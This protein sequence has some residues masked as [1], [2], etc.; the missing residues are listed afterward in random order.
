MRTAERKTQ[1]SLCYN[2]AETQPG[3]A[4]TYRLNALGWKIQ[5]MEVSVN[6]AQL[7]LVVPRFW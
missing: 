5:V 7:Y 3:S 4:V 1:Q 6:D 2:G